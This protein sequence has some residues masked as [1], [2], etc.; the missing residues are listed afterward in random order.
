MMMR[1]I[2]IC[3]KNAEKIKKIGQQQEARKISLKALFFFP[4][5]RLLSLSPEKKKE[6]ENRTHGCSFGLNSSI[7]HRSAF[8][9]FERIVVD[10]PRCQSLVQSARDTHAKKKGFSPFPFFFN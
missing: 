4:T 5:G 2:A 3:E 1:W 8:G 6:K 10:T 7:Y 9:V